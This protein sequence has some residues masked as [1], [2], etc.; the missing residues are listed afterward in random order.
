MSLQFSL[1]GPEKYL[2]YLEHQHKKVSAHESC[3]QW[4]KTHEKDSVENIVN[5]LF[6]LEKDSMTPV[7]M[8][9]QSLNSAMS[10]HRFRHTYSITVR[11]PMLQAHVKSNANTEFTM[12]TRRPFLEIK[13]FKWATPA[14]VLFGLSSCLRKT[15]LPVQKVVTPVT[16]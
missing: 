14:N 9:S 7:S 1:K 3:A 5:C 13:F 15:L 8:T 2:Q 12:F 11:S 10:L 16:Y 4:S 6:N